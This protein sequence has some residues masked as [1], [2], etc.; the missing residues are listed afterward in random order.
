MSV[1]QTKGGA[2]V[3]LGGHAPQNL[4]NYPYPNK[5]NK[6]FKIYNFFFLET[7]RYTQEIVN[8]ILI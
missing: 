1:V 8:K 2:I 3:R 7:N 5:L 4:K 6:F